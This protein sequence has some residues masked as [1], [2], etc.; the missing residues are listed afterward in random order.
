MMKQFLKRI[1]L[2]SF[3]FL[4][5]VIS[6]SLFSK[7]FLNSKPIFKLSSSIHNL[8][9]GHS[10][11]E[12][13]FNDSLIENTKNLSQG[14]EAYFYTYQKT[15]KIIQENPQIK[16]VYLSFSNNQLEKRMDKWTYDDEHMGNY[17][18]KYAAQLNVED[19]LFLVKNNYKSVLA[20]ELKA[21]KNNITFLA[22]NQANYL[23]NN[24]WGGYLYLK[25]NKL[26]SLM[27]IKYIQLVKKN[28]S[29]SVSTINLQYLEKIVDFC[30]TKNVS[31]VLFR[32]P[33][34]NDL[35]SIYDEKK[36][37]DLRNSKFK[38]IPFLDFHDFKLT[39]DEMGDFDHL[40]YKGAKRFSMYFNDFIKN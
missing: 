36:F 6:V 2:Y 3:P 20:G 14:G 29:D 25:R 35:F 5:I 37:Q 11:P 15:K 23:D 21:L 39:N 30:K 13:A 12:C 8:I 31:V 38:D 28:Y 19:Y 26:D 18:P 24:N 33:I 7:K 1:F 27:K 4:I 22:K 16:K 17:F 40:N 10:Q 9:L 32:A 34:H